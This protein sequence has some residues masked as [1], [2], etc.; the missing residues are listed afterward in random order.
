M[1]SRTRTKNGEDI[2]SRDYAK[3]ATEAYRR[4]YRVDEELKP[5]YLERYKGLIVRVCDRLVW[6]EG[7]DRK[8]GSIREK[9]YLKYSSKD[10]GKNLIRCLHK[11]KVKIRKIEKYRIFIDIDK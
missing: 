2:V 10:E 1:K 7:D 4:N 11:A 9:P 3:K 5:E 8:N 6:T